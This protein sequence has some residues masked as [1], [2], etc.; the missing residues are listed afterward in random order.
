MK[1]TP[2]SSLESLLPAKNT[3]RFPGRHK[4]LFSVK[5]LAQYLAVPADTI[6]R[7]VQQGRLP[8]FD[9]RL[10]TKLKRWKSETILERIN[11]GQ[12]LD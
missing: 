10:G 2:E 7:W 3:D 11:N 5:T 8:V 9:V 1:N 12:V 4:G 6:N